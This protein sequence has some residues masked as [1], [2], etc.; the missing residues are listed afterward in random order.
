LRRRNPRRFWWLF[1]RHPRIPSSIPSGY[2]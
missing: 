2:D 1:G